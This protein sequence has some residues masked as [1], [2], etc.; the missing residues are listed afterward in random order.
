MQEHSNLRLDNITGVD[1]W[2]AFFYQPSI[3]SQ[4]I[5]RRHAD[6][7]INDIVDAVDGEM[8]FLTVR[9]APGDDFIND[10]IVG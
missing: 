2:Q 10:N 5:E 3:G 1:R 8:I 9:Q 7:I 4:F 6:F